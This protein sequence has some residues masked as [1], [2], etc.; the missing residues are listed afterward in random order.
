[1]AEQKYRVVHGLDYDGRRAEPGEIVDD[2]PKE[3]I[4]WLLEGGHIT[5]ATK[6]D[7]KEADNGS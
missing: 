4:K 5:K 6:T 7:V 2:I 3:S 1:M